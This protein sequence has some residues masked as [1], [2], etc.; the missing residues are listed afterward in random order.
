MKDHF[1][2]R[3]QQYRNKQT[4][5]TVKFLGTALGN[6]YPFVDKRMVVFCADNDA[7][8]RVMWGPDFFSKFELVV[9]K[10]D[11]H[12]REKFE[13]ATNYGRFYGRG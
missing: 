3:G 13:R 6:T 12:S 8:T 5:E 4:G 1:T 2:Y 10:P 7:D 11:D 9:N